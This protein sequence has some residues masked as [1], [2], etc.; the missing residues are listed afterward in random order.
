[1]C[2]LRLAFPG[3]SLCLVRGSRPLLKQ[4]PSPA[5]GRLNQASV[6]AS[7]MPLHHSESSSKIKRQGLSLVSFLYS[8]INVSYNIKKNPPATRETPVSSLGRKVPWR[9]DRLPT[10]G[11]L[12]FPGGSDSKESACNVGDLGSVPGV[13]RSPGGGHGNPLQHS[14][15]ESPRGQRSR[16]GYSPWGCKELDMTKRLSFYG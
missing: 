15:L 10:P 3:S 1:M 5:L 12:G 8:G 16:V 7:R 9:R 6:N 4:P 11:F 13:G 14:C 2:R